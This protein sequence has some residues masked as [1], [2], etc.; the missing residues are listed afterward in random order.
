MLQ[1][2]AQVALKAFDDADHFLGFSPRDPLLP[3]LEDNCSQRT[4]RGS[5]VRR[6]GEG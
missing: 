4:E 1:A 6:L 2:G 5:V 3:V